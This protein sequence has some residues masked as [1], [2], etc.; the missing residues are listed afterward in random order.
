MCLMQNT[1][2]AILNGLKFKNYLGEHASYSLPLVNIGFLSFMTPHISSA[3][4]YW[5]P[6]DARGIKI[7]SMLW[8]IAIEEELFSLLM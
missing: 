8:I 7:I 3:P 1:Q 5:T 4:Q 6:S 2:N